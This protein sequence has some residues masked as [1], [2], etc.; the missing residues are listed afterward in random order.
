VNNWPAN[1]RKRQK[2]LGRK[3]KVWYS[4]EI[5]HIVLG[6][7]SDGYVFKNGHGEFHLCYKLNMDYYKGRPFKMFEYY[8]IGNLHGRH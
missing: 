8:L 4:P 7:A 2:R 6:K 3:L 5:N 1:Q